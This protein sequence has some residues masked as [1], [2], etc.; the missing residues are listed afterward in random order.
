MLTNAEIKQS[1]DKLALEVA[2]VNEQQV[3]DSSP[4]DG[5]FFTDS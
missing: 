2:T 4:K 1:L 5:L 3:T